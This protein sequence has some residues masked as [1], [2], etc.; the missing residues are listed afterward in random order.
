M[1][2]YVHNGRKGNTMKK[3]IHPDYG[4][5]V[6]RDKTAGTEF[7]TRS[8]IVGDKRVT[9]TI[10]WKDGKTYP[11]YDVEISSASHPFYTGKRTVLDSAGQVG[12]FEKRY[13]KRRSAEK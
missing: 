9:Q 10:E 6:F 13:G 12:K 4:F 8:T 11:L 5:V 7:L 3:D 2:A 1:Y